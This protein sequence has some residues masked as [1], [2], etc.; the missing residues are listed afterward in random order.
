[1]IGRTLFY[2]LLI[3]SLFCMSLESCSEVLEDN[4]NQVNWKKR[5]LKSQLKNHTDQGETYLSIYSEIYSMSEHRTHHLTVTVSIR[6]VNREDTII[7]DRA[8]YFDSKGN[9]L[10]NYFDFAIVLLPLETIEIVIGQE[11]VKGG[12]GA[13]FVFNWRKEEN[14]VD[15]YF[16][17]VMISTSSQQG[18]SF[19]SKGVRVK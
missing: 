4:P 6:N 9:L 18:L 10:T 8:Q 12:T 7:L 11:D 16:E 13:N 15:P 3:L 17:A 2:T 5:R 14:V 19:T 1:M